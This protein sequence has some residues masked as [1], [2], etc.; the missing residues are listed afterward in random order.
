MSFNYHEN[1][2]FRDELRKKISEGINRA[3][4]VLQNA[5]KDTLSKSASPSAPGQ[6]P[7]VVTG[8]LW[9]SVQIDLSRVMSHLVARVGTDLPYGRSLEFGAR[10]RPKRAKA[11]S[12]PLTKE[13]KGYDSPRKFPRDL[14]MITRKGKAPLLAEVA[15][16][17]VTPH[18]ILLMSV[19]IAARP[20]LRPTLD[21]FAPTLP[22]LLEVRS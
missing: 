8:S 14:V 22:K 13:A 10:I 16:K 15:D 21:T 11:L 3:A 7:A 6:P 19:N 1:P 12:V 2:K 17:K 9:R 4:I 5:L 18:Y 20:W